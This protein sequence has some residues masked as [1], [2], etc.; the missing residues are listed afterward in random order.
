MGSLVLQSK[1]HC[2][3]CGSGITRIRT[4]REGYRWEEWCF[5]LGKDRPLCH[6]CAKRLIYSPKYREKLHKTK[7]YKE[8]TAA[9]G[10]R[11]MRYGRKTLCMSFRQLSGYCSK[12][13]NNIFDGSCKKTDMHHLF[14]IIIVPWFG[15]IELCSTC[16]IKTWVGGGG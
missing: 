7:H 8:Y 15:R 5:R 4:S 6:T 3:E 9:R 13:S 11:Y 12:C 2:Y 10:R 14:Y 16:H 1:R